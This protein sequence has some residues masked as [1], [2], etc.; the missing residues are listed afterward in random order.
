LDDNDSGQVLYNQLCARLRVQ[1]GTSLVVTKHGDAGVILEV[2]PSST[3][4]VSDFM[5]S[6][7]CIVVKRA[8][9][10]ETGVGEQGIL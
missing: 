6:G 5:S 1:L 8:D 4:K 10:A 2:T 9:E 3:A 7:D